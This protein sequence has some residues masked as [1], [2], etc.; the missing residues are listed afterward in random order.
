MIKNPLS[1]ESQAYRGDARSAYL[2]RL[3]ESANE[4]RNSSGTRERTLTKTHQE[5]KL[6]PLRIVEKTTPNSKKYLWDVRTRAVQHAD[7]SSSVPILCTKDEMGSITGYKK[8]SKDG[9]TMTQGAIFAKEFLE[10][11]GVLGM[12]WGH[13]KASEVTTQTHTHPITRKTK[14]SSAGGHHLPPHPD[15]IKAEVHQRTLKSSGHAALSNKEL[16]DLITRKQLEDQA[17]IVTSRQGKKFA[18]RQLEVAGQQQV[19]K[20]L[21]TAAAKGAKRLGAI[22]LAAA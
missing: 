10:H 4:M 21:G 3:E 20:G 14:V 12:K 11:H 16:R 5:I 13:R 7:D 1:K 2:T 22:G 15:A 18:Q 17:S 9:E 19:Q 8:H 6:H